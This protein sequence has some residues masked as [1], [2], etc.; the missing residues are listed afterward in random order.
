MVTRELATYLEFVRRLLAKGRTILPRL[1]QQQRQLV[2]R[3]NRDLYTPA[4]LH[5]ITTRQA[6]L[7]HEKPFLFV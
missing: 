4:L 3:L 5:N 1:G 2:D 6:N 7:L